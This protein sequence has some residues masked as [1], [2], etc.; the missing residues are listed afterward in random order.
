ME[1][2][3][4]ESSGEPVLL[5][6]Q[7]IKTIKAVESGV[8]F[9]DVLCASLAATLHQHF[10]EGNNK[11]NNNS[12]DSAPAPPP[13]LPTSITI[14][15]AVQLGEPRKVKMTNDCAYNFERIPITPPVGV[16][17]DLVATLREIR[18]RRAEAAE[19]Q[20]GN[21]LLVRIF[22]VLPDRF[23]RRLCMRNRCSLGLSN[24]VGPT[25][26]EACMVGSEW[27]MRHLSFWTPNRFKTRL[28]LT[29]FSLRNK[30]HL[31]IGG[32]RCSV[33][34]EGDGKKILEGIVREIERM[35]E[36][37]REGE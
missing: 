24:I 21:W 23:L 9:Q 7:K 2:L 14:G 16:R 20:L 8:T 22:S 6:L 32:D 15:N 1:W 25:T 3:Y 13:P 28:C 35:H 4:E 5:L 37:V 11:K 27:R 33:E 10:A 12:A 17:G 36:I 30:L 18:K 31:G 34:E 19:L 26:E 29:V